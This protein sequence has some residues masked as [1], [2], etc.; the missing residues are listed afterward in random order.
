MMQVVPLGIIKPA[1]GLTMLARCYRLAEEQARCPR[2][3]VRLQAQFIVP[4]R[5]RELLQPSR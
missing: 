2:T 5:S 3:M 4:I 1:P